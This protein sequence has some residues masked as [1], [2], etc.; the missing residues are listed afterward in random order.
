MRVAIFTT[1]VSYEQLKKK[2]KTYPLLK[3]SEK[4]FIMVL[5]HG[6]CKSDYTLENYFFAK[7]SIA[8]EHRNIIGIHL[9]YSLQLILE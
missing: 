8:Y 9:L 6:L 3:H 4:I 7:I 5:S 2:K 1:A